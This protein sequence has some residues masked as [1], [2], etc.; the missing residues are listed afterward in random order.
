[1]KK[2][3]LILLPVLLGI[4]IGVG[5]GIGIIGG[6]SKPA[7]HGN[8][9]AIEFEDDDEEVET[10]SAG[11]DADSDEID[12]DANA[13]LPAA[14]VNMTPSDSAPKK[15]AATAAVTNAKTEP[16]PAPQSAAPAE[17]PQTAAGAPK[18]N[19]KPGETGSDATAESD[20]T[21]ARTGD[22]E[23]KGRIS[24]E[25]IQSDISGYYNASVTPEQMAA[26][27]RKRLP[28]RVGKYQTL[29]DFTYGKKDGF[30]YHIR[31]T[32]DDITAKMKTSLPDY[33]CD[34]KQ[35]QIFMQYVDRV[36][37]KFTNN[38]DQHLQTIS[39]PKSECAARMK[40][41]YSGS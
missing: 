22:K 12:L 14:P 17:K 3:T 41:K 5:L 34:N 39:I 21:A 11:E 20:A 40:K 1:M 13:L 38:H 29:T 7:K 15:P 19:P 32:R 18:E 37:F 6:K 36:S 31:T 10:S 24:E 8:E 16:A 30:T 28:I 35:V 23:R 26:D 33:A 25:D 9:I 27:Y 2:K 4:G